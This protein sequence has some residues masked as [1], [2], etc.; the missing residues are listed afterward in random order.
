[1][2]NSQGLAGKWGPI[3][4]A[5]GPTGLAEL[6][7]WKGAQRGNELCREGTCPFLGFSRTPCQNPNSPHSELIQKKALGYLH[8]VARSGYTGG[9]W[10]Q[11]WASAQ[12]PG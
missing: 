8:P 10:G 1:M 9:H 5:R 11:R 2:D 12:C 3:W 4:G 6:K 7:S